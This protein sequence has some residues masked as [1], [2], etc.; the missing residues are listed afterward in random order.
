MKVA[1]FIRKLSMQRSQASIHL[2]S[3]LNVLFSKDRGG[4][5]CPPR[6]NLRH[7]VLSSVAVLFF[8]LA[9][10]AKGPAPVLKLS[11]ISSILA[12]GMRAAVTAQPPHPTS[13]KPV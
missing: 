2:M 13:P 11:V 8:P 3:Q 4:A 5:A 1:A 12:H 9:L 7:I 6:A 10:R